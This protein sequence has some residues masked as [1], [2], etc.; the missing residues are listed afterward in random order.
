MSS[1]LTKHG[2]RI[3]VHP[4]VNTFETDNVVDSSVMSH[5]R[6]ENCTYLIAS[7]LYANKALE[8]L[9]LTQN[10]SK[11]ASRHVRALRKEKTSRT[12]EWSNVVS[13]YWI[14]TR[15]WSWPESTITLASRLAETL[16]TTSCIILMLP[17]EYRVNLRYASVSQASAHQMRQ[18][19]SDPSNFDGRWRFWQRSW[20]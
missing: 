9:S 16:S 5:H 12:E 20:T 1:K 10:S 13:T 3:D 6:P 4:L 8:L 11:I 14:N 15:G 2:W 7:Y 19:D 17:D 18:I